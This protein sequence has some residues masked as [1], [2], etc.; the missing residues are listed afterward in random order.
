MNL[1]FFIDPATHELHIF[2][3]GVTEE[4]ASEI[5]MDPIEDQRS[6][7]NTRIARGKTE[8]GRFIRVVYAEKTT[9][10]VVITAWVMTG[11][12]LQAFKRRNKH[13]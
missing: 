12:E 8:N 7:N 10:I 5:V 1:K 11:K 13:Q 2:N 6:R 4:E 3:H 9:S